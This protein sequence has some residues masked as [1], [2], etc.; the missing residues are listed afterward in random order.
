M[1]PNVDIYD[2]FITAGFN[3][4]TFQLKTMNTSGERE[5]FRIST[6]VA[7]KSAIG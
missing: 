5:Y 6:A 4:D 1:N 7:Q 3:P 2:G